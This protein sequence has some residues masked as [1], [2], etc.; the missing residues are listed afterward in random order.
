MLEAL[1]SSGVKSFS[2]HFQSILE[3]EGG[4]EPWRSLFHPP[5]TLEGQEFHWLLDLHGAQKK[6]GMDDR[7]KTAVTMNLRIEK[8]LLVGVVIPPAAASPL[9]IQ[10]WNE[11]EHT[12][13][14]SG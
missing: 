14:I 9:L 11:L 12:I 7:R 6:A 10:L 2:F 1:G 4:F 5:G 13:M 8:L 3:T